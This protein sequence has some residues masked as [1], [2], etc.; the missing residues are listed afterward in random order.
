MIESIHQETGHSIRRICE[1]LGLPRSSYHHAAKPT[2]TQLDDQKLGDQIEEIFKEHRAR[3]GYRRIY[4][5]LSDREIQCGCDRVRRLMKERGLRAIQPKTFAPQ[6][7]D[8]RADKPSENLVASRAFPEKP[9]EIL[10]GDITYIRTATGWIYL[11]IVIDLCSRRVVGWSLADHMRADLVVE[12][13]EQALGSTPKVAGRIFHSDRGS[14]YGSKAFRKLLKK[15]GML[16]SMSGRAN[17]YDNA[18]TESMIGTL[19]AEMVREGV[20]ENKEEARTELF[21]YLDSYYN[22]KRKHSSLGYQTPSEFEAN[23][24]I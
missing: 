17:P 14:Q 20:F 23:T 12:A 5:E 21:A 2:P 7:S 18:W 1:T 11:A 4:E 24:N 9:N 10:A 22:T 16:Q 19:K 13:L 15:A 8:G 6:T 3:Y